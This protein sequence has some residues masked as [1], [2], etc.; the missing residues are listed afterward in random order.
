[1]HR[2]GKRNAD[3][4]PS[5]N[6]SGEADE[7]H[8]M[9]IR[10]EAPACGSCPASGLHAPGD[11]L[12]PPYRSTGPSHRTRPE[13]AQNIL[14]V[15]DLCLRRIGFEQGKC[16]KLLKDTALI[17]IEIANEPGGR[18]FESLRPLSA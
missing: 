2:S 16:R 1:M 10:P 12:R 4:V 8:S 7:F 9:S 14:A 18:E 11:Q 15:A 13:R 6:L 17:A 5:R 3:P